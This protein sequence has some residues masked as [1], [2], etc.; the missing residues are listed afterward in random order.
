VR[1]DFD[2]RLEFIVSAHDFDF[3]LK[4]IVHD[5]DFKLKFIVHARGR[6]DVQ[7]AVPGGTSTNGGAGAFV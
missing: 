6:I 2:F 1:Y 3:K 5:F 4:F 7:E